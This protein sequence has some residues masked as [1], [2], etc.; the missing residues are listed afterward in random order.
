MNTELIPQIVTPQDYFQILS[1]EENLTPKERSQKML[2]ENFIANCEKNRNLLS[3][4]VEDVYLEYQKELE[5][6]YNNSNLVKKEKQNI[7]NFD[8]RKEEQ[9]EYTRKLTN[10]AGYINATIILVMILNIGFI[11]AMALLGNK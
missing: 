8:L 10:K 11:I 4:A 6:L 3:P 7:I 1:K 5:K 2:F 9:K